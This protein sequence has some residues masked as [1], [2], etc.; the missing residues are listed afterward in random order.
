MPENIVTFYPPGTTGKSLQE[1]VETIE[2]ACRSS[3]PDLTTEPQI[4]GQQTIATIKDLR[5]YIKGC[6][7][8]LI[9]PVGDYEYA[10]SHDASDG[11]QVTNLECLLQVQLASTKEFLS[12][13]S[14]VIEEEYSSDSKTPNC[15]VRI[16]N[17]T[18]ERVLILIEKNTELSETMKTSLLK[19][20]VSVIMDA[21]PTTILSDVYDY[22]TRTDQNHLSDL[23]IE[24]TAK[25]FVDR[26]YDEIQKSKNS[27]RRRRHS[28]I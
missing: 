16:A 27:N 17:K 12:I 3:I 26:Y 28:V 8:Y 1:L 20:L 4:E 10:I 18:I 25:K 14:A 7:E 15:A 9:L 21:V 5:S 13:L 24:C 11:D 6:V 22:V 23:E 2:T 19:M